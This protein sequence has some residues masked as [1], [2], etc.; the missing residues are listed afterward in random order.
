MS[1]DNRCPCQTLINHQYQPPKTNTI[2][3][4]VVRENILQK[5]SGS[6]KA[7][8]FTTI[9]EKFSKATHIKHIFNSLISDQPF[10]P[11]QFFRGSR[12]RYKHKR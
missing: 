6:F 11:K 12:I 1:L 7:I 10:S 5:R 2:L 8:I 4:R 3:Y 9:D